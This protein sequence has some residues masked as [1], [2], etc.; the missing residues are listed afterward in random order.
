MIKDP[1]IVLAHQHFGWR[2][3][4]PETT[5]ARRNVLV[6]LLLLASSG[7]VLLLARDWRPFVPL[8]VGAAAFFALTVTLNLRNRQKAEWFQVAS[9]VALSA[10]CVMVCLSATDSIP[11][12]CWLL[13]FLCALQATAGIFVVHARLDA[14]IAARIAARK[15]A[16][17]PTHSRQAALLCVLALLAAAVCFAWLGYLWIAAA[18]STAGAG[19]WAELMRQKSP[20]SLQAPLAGLHTPPGGPV[21]WMC[22]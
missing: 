8:C 7:G 1:M 17:A 10:T 22:A 13:W 20:E 9:A 6:L 18:L 4:H 14:R 5:G 19:C 21:G 16:G 2:Q 12:W 3:P 11:N 15:P